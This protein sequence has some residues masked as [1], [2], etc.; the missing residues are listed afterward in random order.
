VKWYIFIRFNRVFFPVFTVTKSV[1]ID[2]ET[3]ELWRKTKWHV[4]YGPWCIYITKMPGKHVRLAFCQKLTVFVI[5]SELLLQQN[6]GVAQTE[7][8]C[9]L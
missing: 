7:N 9:G 4:F 3:S 8:L 1:K 2:K 6:N 5:M